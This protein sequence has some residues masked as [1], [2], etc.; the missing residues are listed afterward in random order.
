M[1]PAQY[2]I[3]I[4]NSSFKCRS[5]ETIV[6]PENDEFKLLQ[7]L[8]HGEFRQIDVPTEKFSFFAH[9]HMQWDSMKVNKSGKNVLDYFGF[10]ATICYECIVVTAY[11]PYDVHNETDFKNLLLTKQQVDDF[12]IIFKFC[13]KQKTYEKYSFEKFIERINKY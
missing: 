8:V 7:N 10:R 2:M 6:E 13:K 1:E 9:K 12:R 3:S 5:I 11:H 4:L